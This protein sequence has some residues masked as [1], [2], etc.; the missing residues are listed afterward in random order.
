MHSVPGKKSI[1]HHQ[2][3]HSSLVCRPTLR[4]QSKKAT[5]Y[6]LCP[7]KT[8]GK[9]GIPYTP[10]ARE[11][12]ERRVYVRWIQKGFTAEPPKNDSGPIF[13]EMI[14]I[15]ARKSELQAK[16]R[17]YRPKVRVTAGQ[18]PKIRTESPGKGTRIGFWRFCRGPP[19]KPS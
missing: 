15:S 13:S 6:T 3:H 8:R 4:S 19:L 10:Q 9:N 12:P 2:W 16:S 1:H 14:R 17:S 5:M 18:T 7:G 11:G